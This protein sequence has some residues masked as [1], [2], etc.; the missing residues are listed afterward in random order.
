MSI[1]IF[2]YYQ[3]MTNHRRLAWFAEIRIQILD[4]VVNRTLIPIRRAAES[5]ARLR[6]TIAVQPNQ[7]HK[8]WSA[9]YESRIGMT[10]CQPN[11]N[12][13]RINDSGFDEEFKALLIAA[14][15]STARFSQCF[16]LYEIRS[17][18]N[19]IRVSWKVKKTQIWFFLLQLF[20][21]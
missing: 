6:I 9:D 4:L 12:P 5:K 17:W 3:S 10:K 7:N 16:Q 18:L 13:N 15:N 19:K 2:C 8:S 1:N 11:L 21:M 14:I 20:E